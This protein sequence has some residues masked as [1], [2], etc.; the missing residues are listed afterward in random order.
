MSTNKNESDTPLPTSAT[1]SQEEETE[2]NGYQSTDE[3]TEEELEAIRRLNELYHAVILDAQRAAAPIVAEAMRVWERDE[4][5]ILA[6]LSGDATDTPRA[7]DDD[8][9]EEE[10]ERIRR[11]NERFQARYLA[12]QNRA[13]A[14]VAESMAIWERDE[15]IILEYL[16]HA[17]K[18][19]KPTR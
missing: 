6:F 19:D 8:L 16:K 9:T 1:P 7:P 4:E 12:A 18:K 3:P 2:Q 17:G 10:A 14:V 11:S 5:E 15:E 13:A